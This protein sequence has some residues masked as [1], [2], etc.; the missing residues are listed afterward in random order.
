MPEAIGPG[1]T[2]DHLVIERELGRGAFA[3][4]WLAHDTR[5]ERHVAL[6]LLAGSAVPGATP[7]TLESF[8][9]EARVVAGFNSPHIVTLYRLHERPEGAWLLEMEYMPGGTLTEQI[10]SGLSLAH[11]EAI[12]RDI[13][14]GLGIAHQAGVLHRDVKPGNVLLARDG[15][16]KLSDFGLARMVGDDSL[17]LDEGLVGTPRYMAP[18]VLLGE[19]SSTQS[20]LWS[21]GVIAY[22]MLA[23]R[24]PFSTRD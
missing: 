18:E 2:I 1:T 14:S 7:Q 3:T 5:L 17:L 19:G 4:V 8:L 15:T 12:L 11:A 23:G 20:D 10:R 24:L 21:V 9:A 16:P 22:E 6:K 13:V